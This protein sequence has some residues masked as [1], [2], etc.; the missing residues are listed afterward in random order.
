M[1]YSSSWSFRLY[2]ARFGDI[3][4]HK[5]VIIGGEDILI[6][7]RNWSKY[8]DVFQNDMLFYTVVN[9]ESQFYGS[10]QPS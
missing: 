3:H 10:F 1:K 7:E 6:S 9:D 8:L 4:T 5:N 2:P